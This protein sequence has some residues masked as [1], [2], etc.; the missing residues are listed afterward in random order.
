MNNVLHVSGA[1]FDT[2]SSGYTAAIVTDKGG[3]KFLAV[4]VN[5][6]SSFTTS[7]F[8][9]EITGSTIVSLTTATFL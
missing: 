4:D 5:N 7:D 6:D 9:I 1:G 2:A 3:H 8:V